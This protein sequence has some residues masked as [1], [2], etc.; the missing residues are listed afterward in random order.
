MN[1]CKLLRKSIFYG[2]LC[3]VFVGTSFSCPLSVQ[4]E[5]IT[6]YTSDTPNGLPEDAFS[7]Y[8]KMATKTYTYT[9]QVDDYT[10]VQGDSSSLTSPNQIKPYESFVENPT[11][12][13]FQK[14]SDFT[15]LDSQEYDSS[16]FSDYTLKYTTDED[17]VTNYINAHPELSTVT[18]HRILLPVFEFDTDN[19][20]ATFQN[21]F[22]TDLANGLIPA[23][24]VGRDNQAVIDPSQPLGQ[25]SL[26]KTLTYDAVHGFYYI[27]Q[28][29]V[30]IAD[31][32]R[33][34][35]TFVDSN[36]NE[37]EMNGLFT[38]PAVLGNDILDHKK[39]FHYLIP[40]GKEGD[41]NLVRPAIH[42]TRTYYYYKLAH[43]A[44]VSDDG[45]TLKTMDEG[46]QPAPATISSYTYNH[47]DEAAAVPTLDVDKV[48]QHLLNQLKAQDVTQLFSRANATQ[49][50]DIVIE[51][52]ANNIPSVFVLEP[53]G[54]SY[55]ISYDEN[56][57]LRVTGHDGNPVY[58]DNTFQDVL[59]TT[60]TDDSL[61]VSEYRV[62]YSLSPLIHD[63]YRMDSVQHLFV[64]LVVGTRD[65]SRMENPVDRTHVYTRV[66]N[67]T[68]PT[69]PNT[70]EHTP[71]TADYS[72]TSRDAFVL[73][74]SLFLAICISL[75]RNH[76]ENSPR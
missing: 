57:N 44:Y 76:I 60:A 10:T 54:L 29:H 15:V 7:D 9:P 27:Y 25:Y 68:P 45:T 19:D 50:G 39:V 67:P 40:E 14:V 38:A 56:G 26:E 33:Q 66:P 52:D 61:A 37:T 46:L 41:G 31:V 20:L 42:I 34:I 28:L 47:T 2:L 21:H 55:N 30:G 71:N 3:T 51:K 36:G 23:G 65:D 43:T 8:W 59:Y 72:H 48:T 4:A 35:T 16:L 6:A 63:L 49:V 73:G 13:P 70:L 5:T 32:D 64:N 62:T 69:S 17:A 24:A 75:F 22:D 58:F 12:A 53:S 74:I 18:D 1:A 11:T